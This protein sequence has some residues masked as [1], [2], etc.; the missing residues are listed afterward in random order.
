MERH[1]RPERF[2]CDP[3]ATTASLEWKHW[4][5]TFESFLAALPQDNVD[6]LKVLVNYVTPRVYETISESSTYEDAIAVLKALYVKTPNEVYARHLLATRR[7]QEGESLD[8]YFRALRVLSKDC[9]FKSVTASQHCDESVRDAFISGLRSASIRQR[10][11]ENKTLDLT[12]MF[13]QARSLEA[14]QKNSVFLQ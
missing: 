6:K 9:N 4:Y 5:R 11:L 1:L 2:D 12:S 14:A 3:S 8:E 7:Q 13:D 10:L